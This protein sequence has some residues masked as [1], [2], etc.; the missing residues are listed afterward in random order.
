MGT[1]QLCGSHLRTRVERRWLASVLCAFLACAPVGVAAAQEAVVAG[2]LGKLI[3]LHDAMLSYKNGPVA[4][5]TDR[6]YYEQFL[7]EYQE[8]ITGLAVESRVD[9][10]WSGMWHLGFDG[11]VMEEFQSLILQDCGD[12]FV[13]R[14]Q[15]YISQERELGKSS[16]RLQLAEKVLAGLQLVKDK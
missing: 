4:F 9:F 15:S 14:L 3:L 10:F 16:S 1:R 6:F 5:A 11:H 13:V 8:K 2:S 12:E 7:P